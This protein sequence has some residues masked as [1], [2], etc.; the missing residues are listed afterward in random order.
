M[1]A[2]LSLL[3]AACLLAMAPALTAADDPVKSADTKE[4]A[5]G[6][7]GKCQCDKKAK[8]P[9]KKAVL[10]TG[11]NIPQKVTQVGR[12]TDSAQPLSVISHDDLER[13]GEI[14]LASALRK[15]SPNI[16]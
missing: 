12:I 2:K 16:H 6:E 8:E 5:K 1:N 7:K 14:N 3:A 10:L 11:S 4:T 13:T 15:T 9:E